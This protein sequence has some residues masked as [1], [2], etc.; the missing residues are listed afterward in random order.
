MQ[1][2]VC[3][4]TCNILYLAREHGQIFYEKLFM[5]YTSLIPVNLFQKEADDILDIKPPVQFYINGNNYFDKFLFYSLITG[6]ILS[7]LLFLLYLI[8]KQKT[9]NIH[10]LSPDEI[11]INMISK[12]ESLNNPDKKDFYFRLSSIFINYIQERS[13]CNCVSLTIEQLIVLIND[14]TDDNELIKDVKSILRLWDEYKFA[15]STAG[16]DQIKNH[17]FIVKRFIKAT[18]AKHNCTN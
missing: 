8:L 16:S 13:G 2:I 9:K 18:T 12:L 7:V 10:T 5:F 3:I 14:L 17:L 1:N 11:A 4:L 15:A 6:S